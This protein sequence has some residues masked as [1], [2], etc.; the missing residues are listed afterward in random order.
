MPLRGI[1]HERGPI[2]S[3]FAGSRAVA[4][5]SSTSLRTVFWALSFPFGRC[6]N[7]QL[8]FSAQYRISADR[9]FRHRS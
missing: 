1:L 9:L 2:C 6:H 7:R 5:P 8:L 3:A 4:A